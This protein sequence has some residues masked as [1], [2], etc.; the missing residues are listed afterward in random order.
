MI[1]VVGTGAAAL[2]AVWKL[3]Q[4]G[5]P[6]AE[7]LL[8]E[9]SRALGG[10]L[11]SRWLGKE[12]HPTPYSKRFD[13]G[14]PYF[15]LPPELQ[16]CLHAHQ[17][18][19]HFKT[20]PLPVV[21]LDVQG[22]ITDETSTH[23]TTEELYYCDGGNNAFFKDAFA[24]YSIRFDFKASHLREANG[25]LWIGDG[26]EEIAAAK[27]ILTMPAPQAMELLRTL[28]PTTQL[29]LP[30]NS[31]SE[32]RYQKA[33]VLLCAMSRKTFEAAPVFKDFFA[34]ESA[35]GKCEIALICR[36]RLKRLPE[37][38]EDEEPFTVR[39]SPEFSGQH[40]DADESTVIERIRAH[41][42]AA[43]GIDVKLLYAN[44]KKWR[45]ALCENPQV[46]SQSSHILKLAG[47]YVSNVSGGAAE[48]AGT[49]GA[50]FMSGCR[51]AEL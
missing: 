49:V 38:F 30:I 35:N 40:Y 15:S 48:K 23:I 34:A 4:Q 5:V 42:C 1:V 21:K 27:V 13:H 39:M 28:E 16:A 33:L 43:F 11:A 10:R 8:L 41:L 31:L 44:V 47:D 20:L 50:A 22:R 26:S 14:A 32:V 19:H 18:R 29:T 45:Y 46:V 6:P 7:I 51:A 24:G 2:G 37:A 12:A 36:E 17:L 25:T 9:K 3:S